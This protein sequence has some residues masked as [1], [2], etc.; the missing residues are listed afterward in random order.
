MH[1]IR[2]THPGRITSPL[3]ISHL[4]CTLDLFLAQIQINV[5]PSPPGGHADAAA[6]FFPVPPPLGRMVVV[7]AANAP[8]FDR[9]ENM[10][11]SVQVG[12][13]CVDVVFSLLLSALNA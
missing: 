13:V 1:C 5:L 11:A 12:E 8:F 6:P 4:T 3:Q 7:S 10:V 2:Y 9:L